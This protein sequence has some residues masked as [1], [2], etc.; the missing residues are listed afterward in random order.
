MRRW[1][2]GL[3]L[4]MAVALVT[5]RAGAALASSAVAEQAQTAA[6]LAEPPEVAVAGFPFL[7]QALRGRY[8]RV[9]VQA[10]TVA[11]GDLT[12]D[13]LQATFTGVQVPLSQALSGS[14]ER[15]PV[16]T[17]EARALVSYAE[18]SRRSGDRQL[19]VSQADVNRVRVTGQLDVL[20][21]T[22]SAAAVSRVEVVDGE[23]VVTAEEYET[24]DELDDA[25]LSRVLGDRL[26]LRVPV[27][28][29]PYG[30]QVTDVAIEPDGIRVLATATDT[31][32]SPG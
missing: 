6:G 9:E 23:I 11:A 14:I 26:D 2:I 22:L 7:T 3:G 31:V 25:V 13:R 20:G 29:L 30:L 17:V 21:G 4:L 19:T 27:R 24:G 8:D 32:L 15:V 1:L 5:D 10:T 28:G 18:L 16:E 12:V